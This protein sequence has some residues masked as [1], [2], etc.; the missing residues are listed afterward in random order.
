[1]SD[2]I[3]ERMSLFFWKW[4]IALFSFVFI[5][6]AINQLVN[7]IKAKIH[8]KYWS[9]EESEYNKKVSRIIWDMIYWTLMTFN[10]LIC[11]QILGLDVAILMA[12]ISFGIWFA[13]Q[14]TLSNM[15]SG[16]MLIINP[17]FKTG[18]SVQLLWKYNTFAKIEKITIRNCVFRL[19]NWR[20]LIL[21]NKKVIN[22]PLK[23]RT[24]PYLISNISIVVDINTNIQFAKNILR[25]IVNEH[26]QIMQKEQTRVSIEKI[27]ENWIFLKVFYYIIP[28]WWKKSSLLIKSNL[29]TMIIK[30]FKENKI[31]IPYPHQVWEF[32]K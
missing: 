20:R 30:S 8:N 25:N 32:K 4:L 15:I 22:T 29:R 12:G 5:M 1:M 7:I 31:E 10:F 17:D 3:I 11:F 24:E 14:T 28:W 6:F 2:K 9:I 13:M 19:L 23:I 18:K 21:P 26:N 27:N 16:I